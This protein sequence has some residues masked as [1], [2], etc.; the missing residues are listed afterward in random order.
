MESIVF[1]EM[2]ENSVIHAA[3]GTFE[4][5]VGCIY[6]SFV[7]FSVFIHHDVC[8]EDVVHISVGAESVRGDT[9]DAL[10]FRCLGSYASENRC[11]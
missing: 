9:K 2:E 4:V 11:P 6:V 5:R 1:H 8:G 7:F 3:E 10:S